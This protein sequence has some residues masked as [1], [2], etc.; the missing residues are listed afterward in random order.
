MKLTKSQLAK[1]INEERQ[2]LLEQE[3]KKIVREGKTD[4]E[5]KAQLKRLAMRFGVP[6]AIVAGIASGLQGQG[7]PGKTVGYDVGGDA[8]TPAQQSSI[9]SEHSEKIFSIQDKMKEVEQ[10]MEETGDPS[11]ELQKELEQLDRRLDLAH[12]AGF[13]AMRESK[14][15]ITKSQ[16]AKII[17]EEFQSV[18][19]AYDPPLPRSTELPVDAEVPMSPEEQRMDT[20]SGQYEDDMRHHLLV[21]IEVPD[22]D[23]SMMPL[24][25]FLSKLGNYVVTGDVSEKQAGNIIRQIQYAMSVDPNDLGYVHEKEST[26][27]EDF[28]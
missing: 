23:G 27:E 1:I 7:A 20:L 6:L 25:F 12:Q 10:Q 18:V 17:K 11:G 21:G 28:R 14:Q 19:E 13:Q 2:A 15:K 4:K 8:D 3:I 26:E 16:L 24:D 9:P 22:F 5:N